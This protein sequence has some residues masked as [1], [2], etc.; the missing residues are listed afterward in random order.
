MTR[1]LTGFLLVCLALPAMA[2]T[3][4]LR[5]PA[6]ALEAVIHADE[7]LTLE[8]RFRGRT[9]VR[10]PA[11]GLDMDGHLRANALPKLSGTAR[12]K[13]NETIRPV[14]AEKRAVI[15]DRYNELRLSFGPK[16]A[17]TF[18]VYDDGVAYRF[19][20]A[21]DGEVIVRNEHAGLRLAKDDSALHRAGELPQRT[22][23]RLLPVQ[24]RRELPAAE[25]A[26]SCRTDGLR[27][28]PITVQTAGA[29][30]GFTE[31]DLRDYPGIVAARRAG[32]AGARR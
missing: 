22:G 4:R 17:V 6:E 12:R 13:V 9:V 20:T 3:F 15:P 16:L 1:A 23:R 14:V 8:V 10:T 28:L 31:S 26:M 18:R 21:I 25:G 29:Y 2:E 5:A 7:M 11:I 27:Y 32:R 24:L 30:L 19:E